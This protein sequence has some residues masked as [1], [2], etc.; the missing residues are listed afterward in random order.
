[1]ATQGSVPVSLICVTRRLVCTLALVLI[2]PATAITAGQAFRR[3]N[4]DETQVICATLSA[5]VVACSILLWRR[6]VF[7][8]RGRKILTALVGMVPF[9]Q[10]VYARPL[11]NTGWIA[12]EMLCIGQEH[13]GISL[14]IWLTVWVWWGP[15]R[16]GLG[17]AKNLWR[18]QMN[19]SDF[20]CVAA[21]IGILPFAVGV[22]WVAAVVC[23]DL[24]NPNLGYE[25]AILGGYPASL[26]CA[27]AAWLLI[28]R[29]Q[30]EWNAAIR[31]RTLWNTL[32]LVGLPLALVLLGELMR[33]NLW[34]GYLDW[35]PVFAFGLWMIRTMYIWPLRL[36]SGEQPEEGP[37]CPACGYLLKGLCHTR[38]PECGHEPT[39]DQLWVANAVCRL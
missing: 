29:R 31:R 18:R 25:W 33:I 24:A 4:F 21:S 39:L 28:W 19:R 34:I 35:L 6:L 17:R 23:Y 37:L 16:R 10:V 30:V 38:C 26:G 7:W 20:R 2:A 11:W 32:L 13:L 12:D 3:F 15:D 8:T 9:V 1:M 22:H 14:W 5:T 27:V 36:P